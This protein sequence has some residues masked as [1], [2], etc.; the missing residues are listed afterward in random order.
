M[1]KKNR[2]V[3]NGRQQHKSTY[4]DTTCPVASLLETRILALIIC[5]RTYSSCTGDSANAY[6]H[7][8]AGDFL[9]IIIP[10]ESLGDDDK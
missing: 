3:A 10:G 7:A 9:L 4:T 6:L 2:L 5:A 8:G 1:R